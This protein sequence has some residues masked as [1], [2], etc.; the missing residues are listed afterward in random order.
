MFNFFRVSISILL[1]FL[2]NS[3]I[4]AAGADSDIPFSLVGNLSFDGPTMP[5]FQGE[6][7]VGTASSYT[8]RVIMT[9]RTNSKEQP[10][11]ISAV[12]LSGSK[13][14]D[15]IWAE[16][17][18]PWRIVLQKKIS[19]SSNDFPEVIIANTFLYVDDLVCSGDI[20]GIRAGSLEAYYKKYKNQII[21]KRQNLGRCNVSGVLEIVAYPLLN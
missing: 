12:K 16:A 10:A 18:L 1:I 17:A 11:T 19:N 2:S 3:S 9:G 4:Y 5:G 20:K 13:S 8:C 15:S 7:P 6:M 14:C 21:I